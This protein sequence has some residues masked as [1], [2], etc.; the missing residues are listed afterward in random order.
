MMNDDEL[1]RRL[2]QYEPA[3]PP[4]SLRRS[5][6]DSAPRRTR[7][8]VLAAFAA[9]V[10][11]ILV[12]RLGAALTYADLMAV[13]DRPRIESRS[14]EIDAIADRFGG[15]EEARAEAAV[16][17]AQAEATQLNEAGPLG[18]PR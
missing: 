13:V 1:V 7:R 2:R 14:A 12:V 3:S 6:V 17:V 16:Q 4:V 5:V 8:W 9:T 10:L 11:C 15:G 18:G